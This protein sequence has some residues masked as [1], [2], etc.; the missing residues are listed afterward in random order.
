MNRSDTTLLG[1]VRT[2][3]SAAPTARAITFD[4]GRISG[5]NGTGPSSAGTI[6]DAGTRTVLPGFIDT[7]AHVE[8]ASVL[9]ATSVDVRVPICRSVADVL[10]RLHEA[11]PT[12]RDGWLIG[13][14]NLFYDQ[15]LSDGRYPTLAEL[16]SVSRDV[17]IVIRAGGHLSVL[18]SKAMELA[19]IDRLSQLEQGLMGHAQVFLD[20]DGNRTGVVAEIDGLLPLPVPSDA[21]FAQLVR[22][23]VAAE[24]TRFGVTTLGEISETLPG[25]RAMSKLAAQR[26]LPSRVEAY[27]WAPGTFGYDE[28]FKWRD[29][30]IAETPQMFRVRGVKMFA[31]GGFTAQNAA[32]KKPFLNGSCGDL[33]LSQEEIISM[34]AQCDDAGLQL[35]VHANGE[36]AQELMCSAI[37]AGN[38]VGRGIQ[39]RLEHAGN[40]LTDWAT[41]DMWRAADILPVPQAVFIGGAAFLPALLGDD[42]KRGRFPFR[43]LIDQGWSLPGSSDVHLGSEPTHTNPMF[44]VW[45]AVTRI[46]HGGELIEPDEALTVEQA[47]QM[48]TINGAR[49]LGV[50]AERGSLESGK[51]ADMVVLD[52]DLSGVA[53]HDL[54]SVQVDYVFVDGQQVYERHGAKPL[55]RLQTSP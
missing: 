40:F 41:T 53:D 30:D 6:L 49:T 11:L 39:T 55:D 46:G 25:L 13:R 7:H 32:V 54:H 1:N 45:S 33:N 16:D 15:R 9:S 28:V 44:G 36:R 31:D 4:G 2:M 18:N 17:A 50:D 34:R 12:A 21:E 23:G 51:L 47:L 20:D 8:V 37:I 52:R 22:T 27:L 10:A 26:L 29:H 19:D 14:A 5:V 48:Y 43:T 35:A 24:F 3:N 38:F 42:A